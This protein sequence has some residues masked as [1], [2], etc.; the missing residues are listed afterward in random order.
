MRGFLLELSLDGTGTLVSVRYKRLS[1]LSE[2]VI[3]EVYCIYIT[4]FT[5]PYIVVGNGYMK[6]VN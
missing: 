6:I 4:Q 3:R 5:I 1:G 2:D